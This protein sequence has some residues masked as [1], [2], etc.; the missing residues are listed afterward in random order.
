MIKLKTILAIILPLTC[1]RICISQSGDSLLTIIDNLPKGKI[2]PLS[3]IIDS[4]IIHS[5]TVK[6]YD[7]LVTSAEF[8]YDAFKKSWARELSLSFESKLGQYG[9]NFALDGLGLGYGGA[10]SVNVPL[11]LFVGR[12]SANEAR[13]Y[14][15]QATTHKRE[16][17]VQILTLDIINRYNLLMVAEQSLAIRSEAFTNAKLNFEYA[18]LQFNENEIR[19]GEYVKINDYY[20]SCKLNFQQAKSNYWSSILALEKVAGIKIIVE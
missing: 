10:L 3:A 15:Y 5:P 13:Y 18:K 16:E 17:I 11:S 9:N 2:L 14:S 1:A 12:K 7:A 8:D 19:I 6:Q 4:A 20:M